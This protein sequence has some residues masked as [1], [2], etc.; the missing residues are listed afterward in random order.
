LATAIFIPDR[1][2]SN[3]AE[4]IHGIHRAFVLLGAWT[5]LST[6][7]FSGLKRGDGDSVAGHKGALP[8]G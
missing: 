3:P 6:L 7:I 8:A 4:M 5:I 2:N 1:F